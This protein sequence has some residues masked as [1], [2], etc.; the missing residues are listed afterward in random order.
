MTHAGLPSGCVTYGACVGGGG[1]G[2]VGAAV[3]AGGAL[4]V[5]AAV[6]VTAS[7]VGVLDA[8][9]GAVLSPCPTAWPPSSPPV[10][11]LNA[12]KPAA[13]IATTPRPS[14]TLRPSDVPPSPSSNSSYM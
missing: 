11:A 7:V 6:V 3:V 2:G 14:A 10:T 4:V 12:K 9:D 1:G 5:G 13:A 8:T